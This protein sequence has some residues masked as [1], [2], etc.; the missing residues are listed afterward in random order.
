M[1]ASR[2]T[3]APHAVLLRH[4]AHASCMAHAMPSHA[5][6]MHAPCEPCLPHAA[7]PHHALHAP[8]MPHAIPCAFVT[9]CA[10][11]GP[12]SSMQIHA[13]F[14]SSSA[15]GHCRPCMPACSQKHLH[16]FWRAAGQRR[17]RKQR[18]HLQRAVVPEYNHWQTRK[19]HA[20]H[21]AQVPATTHN[22]LASHHGCPAFVR[23]QN[24]GNLSA[25]S[26]L[27]APTQTHGHLSAC[28]GLQA[29]SAILRFPAHK[30]PLAV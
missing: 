16:A 4:A 8:R 18:A 6:S 9:P 21:H 12:C 25:C 28:C 30:T 15:S 27:Q 3:C 19:W 10:A 17:V 7:L 24:P 13:G 11:C 1:H 29:Y 22:W 2:V 14:A 23:A 20:S 26:V 5:R